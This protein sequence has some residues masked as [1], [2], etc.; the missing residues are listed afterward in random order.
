MKNGE[1]ILPGFRWS[2]EQKK[3]EVAAAAL[4]L[5]RRK[6]YKFILDKILVRIS[7]P[8]NCGVENI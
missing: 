1:V 8:F 2:K 4:I 5:N 3:I 6:I 7:A